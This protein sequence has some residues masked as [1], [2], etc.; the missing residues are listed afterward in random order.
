MFLTCKQ[1]SNQLSNEDYDRLSPF[2]KATLKFHVF[3]CPVCGK[4]NRMVM[5]FQDISRN[6][7]LKEEEQLESTAPDAPHLSEEA[8]AKLQ[9]TLSQAGGK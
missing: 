7:R 9:E 6:F 5:K 1:V 3:I 8:R 2:R 4:Y